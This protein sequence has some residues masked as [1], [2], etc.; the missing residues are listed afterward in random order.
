[1]IDLCKREAANEA[2][3][4]MFASQQPGPVILAIDEEHINL[5]QLANAV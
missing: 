5:G 4:G 1:M 2:K 3:K